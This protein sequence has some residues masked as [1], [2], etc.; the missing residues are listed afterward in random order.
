MKEE[1][2]KKK[3]GQR[4]DRENLRIKQTK[5]ERSRENL[6]PHKKKN[7]NGHSFN[8]HGYSCTAHMTL[9]E[10]TGSESRKLLLLPVLPIFKPT[11]Y[12]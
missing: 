7:H 12:I 10:R 1:E 3:K 11:S 8:F 6:V 9:A 2:E 4:E 5:L